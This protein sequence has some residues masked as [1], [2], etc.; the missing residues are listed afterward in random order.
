MHTLAQGEAVRLALEGIPRLLPD[1][2]LPERGRET[3]LAEQRGLFEL[4]LEFLLGVF[5]LIRD[6]EERYRLDVFAGVVGHDPQ[7]DDDVRQ[8]YARWLEIADGFRQRAE[9]FGRQHLPLD[10]AS[11]HDLALFSEKAKEA[12]TAWK[13]PKLS[14]SPAF[15]R[16]YT[17]PEVAATMG[18]T[19]P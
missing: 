10:R 16:R 13:T 1:E 3:V 14:R 18:I 9:F 15:R 19:G 17:T 5:R 11:V 6:L 8:L 7:A 2:T 4:Y 12:G